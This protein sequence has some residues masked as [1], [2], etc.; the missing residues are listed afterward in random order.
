MDRLKALIR[1]FFAFSRKETNAF[2]ILLPLMALLI[3][4]EPIYRYFFTRQK[5]DFTDDKK[6]LDSLVSVLRDS[7]KVENIEPT[8]SLSPFDPNQANQEQ[9]MANGFSASLAKRIVSYR[10]KGGKFLVKSDLMKI[11]GLDET[12]Y[13]SVYPYILLPEKLT[14]RKPTKPMAEA[15]TKTLNR[16]RAR[17]DLNQADTVQLKRVYG[18]G[19]KLSQ[20]I[21]KYREKLGGFISINQLKEVYGLDSTVI[22]DVA[23]DFFIESTFQPRQI[24]INAAKQEELANHPYIHR[25]LARTIEAYRFQ[26]GNFTQLSDLAKVQ[27]MK[28]TTLQKLTPYLSFEP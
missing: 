23:K 5:Q 9:L 19:D 21:I 11:Y 8:I 28:E 26:H 3:F 14:E 22:E 7:S 4:S 13:E 18:I 24:K 1:S 15:I 17:M 20:R 2:L 6:K 16:E 27:M 12:L 10:T 25:A